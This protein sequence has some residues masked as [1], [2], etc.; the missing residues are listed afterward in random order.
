MESIFSK[1][2]RV[3]FNSL[4]FLCVLFCCFFFAFAEISAPRI[5][6]SRLLTTPGD[7]NAG[8]QLQ[9]A[10]QVFQTADT[11]SPGTHPQLNTG[12]QIQQPNPSLRRGSAPAI[13]DFT[14]VYNTIWSPTENLGAPPG[15][16]AMQ[17]SSSGSVNAL[18]LQEKYT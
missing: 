5:K 8:P 16:F 7:P 15:T 17:P 18:V 3:F 13:G 1:K 9:D 2:N 4:S 6:L 12:A 10:N 11:G 14:P